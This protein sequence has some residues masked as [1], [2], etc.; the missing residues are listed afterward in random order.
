MHSIGLLT[1]YLTAL[2]AYD[3]YGSDNLFDD[4]IFYTYLILGTQVISGILTK[5]V[6][7]RYEEK[8]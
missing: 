8:V 3:N 5:F 2:Y 6:P 1:W 4:M 7:D